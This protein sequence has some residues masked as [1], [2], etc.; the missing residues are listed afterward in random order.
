M[1]LLMRGARCR[2]PTMHPLSP[3]ICFRSASHSLLLLQVR[4]AA[5]QGELMRWHALADA[6]R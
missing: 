2:S 4:L 5:E 3:P 6:R 1:R